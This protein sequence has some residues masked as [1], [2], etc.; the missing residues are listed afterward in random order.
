VP[1]SETAECYPRVVWP[2]RDPPADRDALRVGRLYTR[3]ACCG[4]E[5]PAELVDFVTSAD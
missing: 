2:I 5:E 1:C 3:S 4:A